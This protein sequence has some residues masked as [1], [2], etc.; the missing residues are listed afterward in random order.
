MV[1]PHQSERNRGK[2][3]IEPNCQRRQRKITFTFAFA[4]VLRDH[5]GPGTAEQKRKRF[6]G[7]MGTKPNC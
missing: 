2:M 7:K 4:L 6:R 5:N 3:G 1:Q